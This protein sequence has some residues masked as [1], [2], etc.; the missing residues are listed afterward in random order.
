MKGFSEELSPNSWAKTDVT[1]DQDDLRDLL[2]E[3]G[4]DFTG[5]TTRLSYAILSAEV[6]R[7][8]TV[9]YVLAHKNRGLEV[10][11]GAIKRIEELSALVKA[12]M[13]IVAKA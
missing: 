9:E 10:P 5:L 7:L 2:L 1:L 4:R 12:K 11:A 13:A 6:E 8:V 3:D